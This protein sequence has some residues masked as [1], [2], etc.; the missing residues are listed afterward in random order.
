MHI[1][2]TD[3]VGEKRIDLAYLIR[4][5]D[6]SKEVTIISKFSDNIQYQIREPLKVLRI[7]N[8]EKQLPEWVFMD[9]ELHASLGRKLITIPLDANDNIVKMDKLVCITEMVISLDE[10][11]NTDTL[12]GG[13]LSNVLLRCHVTGS[14]EFTSFEPVTPQYKRL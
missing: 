8:E 1:T 2:I 6:S 9:R 14:Q 5:L 7:T 12:E 4:N 3:V 10:L 11:N 13:R